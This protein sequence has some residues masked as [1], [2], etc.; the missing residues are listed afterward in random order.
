M[1]FTAKDRLSETDL[2]TLEMALQ[3]D[4]EIECIM[5]DGYN[6]Y[7]RKVAIS[8]NFDYGAWFLIEGHMLP[9]VL[10]NAL[11]VQDALDIYIEDHITLDEEP[12]DEDDRERGYTTG[13][14]TWISEV[15]LSYINTRTGNTFRGLELNF[16][17]IGG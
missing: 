10:I 14:G 12:E 3:L 4:A 16:N 2:I 1:R 17:I 13:N 7:N 9:S 6:T 5:D 11:H 15:E 8:D